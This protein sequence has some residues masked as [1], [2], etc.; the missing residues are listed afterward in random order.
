MPQASHVIIVLSFG[1]WLSGDKVFSVTSTDGRCRRS[2]VW[3]WLAGLGQ[4]RTTDRVVGSKMTA[5]EPLY[6]GHVAGPTR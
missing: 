1:D 2:S 3:G 5:H 4:T 6:V